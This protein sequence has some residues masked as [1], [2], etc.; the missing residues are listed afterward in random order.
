[1]GRVDKKIA[2]VTG[3]GNGIGRAIAERLAVEGA[4]VTVTDQNSEA[5]KAVADGVDTMQFLEH[6]VR[7][8]ADWVKVMA[9]VTR[10][11]GRLDLLINNAGILATESSQDVEN[12]SLDQ[13][14][15]VNAVNSEG[16]F[17]GCQQGIEAMKATGGSIVNLSSI[18]ALMATPHLSAYGASKAAVRQLTKTVAVHCGRKGYRIRCN[19]VHPGVIQTSMGDHVMALGGGNV[20]QKWAARIA[21]I[22]LGE[23]GTV[24]DVASCVLFLASDEA[25]HITGAEL[26]VDGGMTIC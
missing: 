5:G 2:I 15:T 16:V 25:R 22:P 13:W 8:E 11:H 18:A 12:T 4:I 21:A 17:L 14:R 7:I 23:A 26:V 9:S 10:Q 20:E 24:H 19:S 1:M 6:D 3:G